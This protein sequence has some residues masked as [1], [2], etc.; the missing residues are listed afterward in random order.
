VDVR[1]PESRLGP[2]RRLRFAATVSGQRDDGS[3]F[4]EKAT[5]RDLS[6]QGAYL[7]LNSRPR[8]QSELRVVIETAREQNRSSVLSLRAAVVYCETGREKSGNGV[9]VVFVEDGGLEPPRD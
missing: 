8:L 4:E 2:R 7:C 1:L 3:T 9:G 6:L 5:V